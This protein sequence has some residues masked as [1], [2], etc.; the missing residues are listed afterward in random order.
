MKKNSTW[1]T[2]KLII[3]F[4]LVAS[5]AAWTYHE[6]TNNLL[7]WDS[8]HYLVR[9]I[10]YISSLSLDNIIWMFLALDPNWHPLTWLSWTVYCVQYI[11][12]QVITTRYQATIYLIIDSPG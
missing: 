4:F 11:V 5:F 2:V 1:T 10:G 6:S 12:A 7:V 3:T 9:N 8:Y